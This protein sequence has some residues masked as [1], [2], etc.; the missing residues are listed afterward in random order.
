[1]VRCSKK[2]EEVKNT[3]IAARFGN[4]EPFGLLFEPFG[5]QYFDLATFWATFQKLAKKMVFSIIFRALMWIFL[6]FGS[7]LMLGF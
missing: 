5:V 7:P 2:S 6:T 1:M 4:L 3:N